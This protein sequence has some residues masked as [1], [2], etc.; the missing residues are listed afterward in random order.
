MSDNQAQID[1]WNGR[2][3]ETWVGAQQRLDNMLEALTAV[4][5]AKA[6]PQPGE[7]AIDVGCGCGTTTFALADRGAAVWGIDISGPMLAQAKKRGEAYEHVA[8]SQADAATQALTPDHQLI[9]SRFGVM[10]FADPVA[11]CKNLR[12]GLT[13]DGRMVFMCWQAPRDNPWVSVGGRA[14][15]PFLP[16]GEAID[17][18]AP[19]PFAFADA[20]YLRSILTQAGFANVEIESVTMDLCVGDDLD[21]AMDFQA[22]V[23]PMA[24]ALAELDGEA[25]QQ[26]AEAARAALEPFVTPNGVI[27]GSAVWLV[28]A[29]EQEGAS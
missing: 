24:R 27:L 16:E 23:G 6:D 12:T 29:T 19:G 7:R 15:Q 20:D 5:I 2:A 8:F 10:F 28:S 4:A 11:A 17:P 21:A 25:Q 22:Q 9:F 13:D 14:L 1:Y 26:A 18:K 3:G